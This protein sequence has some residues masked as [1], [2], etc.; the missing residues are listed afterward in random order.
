MGSTV[1]VTITKGSEEL[2]AVTMIDLLR[3]AE[4]EVT[5]ASCS[6]SL[7]VTCSRYVNLVA[8]TTLDQ[9]VNRDW[10]LIALPGGIQGSEGLRDTPELIS[11]LKRQR[12]AGRWIAAICMAPATVLNYHG[13]L[14]NVPATCYPTCLNQLPHPELNLKVPVVRDEASKIVTSRGPGTAIEFALELICILKG[15]DVAIQVA[16]HMQAQWWKKIPSQV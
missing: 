6:D 15:E 1:L 13:F 3:R 12:R 4:C 8:D 2:E 14:D 16:E 10:D 5:V 7:Q 11:L 9:C